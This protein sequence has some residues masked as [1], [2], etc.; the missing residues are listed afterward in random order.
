MRWPRL[1]WFDLGNEAQVAEAR[2]A[3]RG[4]PGVYFLRVKGRA[5]MHYIGSSEPGAIQRRGAPDPARLWKTVNRHFQAC[6]SRGPYSFGQDNF[7]TTASERRRYE[8]AV[9]LTKTGADARQVESDAIAHFAP[10][11]NAEREPAEP[12]D[13]IPF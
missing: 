8:L 10:V 7:C 6:R 3:C 1:A 5:R 9:L 4:R 13:G 2:A 12:D 11:D